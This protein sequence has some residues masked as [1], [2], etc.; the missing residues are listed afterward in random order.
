MRA[1]NKAAYSFCSRAQGQKEGQPMIRERE[2]ILD[3][4]DTQ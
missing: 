4:K 3:T 2:K 1:T